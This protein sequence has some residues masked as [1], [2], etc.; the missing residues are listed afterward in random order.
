MHPG[1]LGETA[2]LM[3][4]AQIF[5]QLVDHLVDL[6]LLTG[7][8]CNTVSGTG[9]PREIKEW[10]AIMDYLRDLPVNTRGELPAIPVDERA[11]EIRAIQDV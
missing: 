11:A 10:Q 2:L 6:L 8:F 5:D 7:A 9:A 1:A 4:R 3:D